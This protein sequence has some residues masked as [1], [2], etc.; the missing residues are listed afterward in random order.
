M[1]L[2]IL[3]VPLVADLLLE[4]IRSVNFLTYKFL[5]PLPL[6]DEEDG[7]GSRKAQLRVDL[8]D[9]RANVHWQQTSQHRT[10]ISLYLPNLFCSS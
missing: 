1:L 6:L 7:D 4:S 3:L 9:P 2:F 8:A 10:N 5:H